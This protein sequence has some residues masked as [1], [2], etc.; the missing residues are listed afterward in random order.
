M[1]IVPHELIDWQRASTVEFNEVR[2]KG[3]HVALA[4]DAPAHAAAL[5]QSPHLQRHLDP[6][7]RTAHEARSA[8]RREYLDRSAEG[9][10]DTCRLE[11]PTGST[12]AREASDLVDQLR[13]LRADGVRRPETACERQAFIEH[14]DRDDGVA[15]CQLRREQPSTPDGPY[16]E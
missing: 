2:Q 13:V 16:A 15:S 7:T 14:V 12:P 10:G 1:R 8:A 9:R 6:S 3:L 4:L 5:L 11:A